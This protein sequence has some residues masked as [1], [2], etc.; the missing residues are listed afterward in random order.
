MTRRIQAVRV[1]KALTHGPIHLLL[2]EM[3]KPNLERAETHTRARSWSGAQFRLK[4][5]FAAPCLCT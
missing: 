1:T 5:S 3:K 4:P 2:G